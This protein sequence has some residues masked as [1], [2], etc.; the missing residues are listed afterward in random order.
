MN[1]ANQGSAVERGEGDHSPASRVGG[2]HP[3]CGLHGK[4]S[5]EKTLEPSYPFRA[6]NHTFVRSNISTLLSVV[7][8]GCQGARAFMCRDRF[9]LKQ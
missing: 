7:D 3:E 6:L 9:S 4:V 8:S 5:L 2:Y 1:E